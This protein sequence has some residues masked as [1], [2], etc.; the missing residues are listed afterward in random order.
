MYRVNQNL[1]SDLTCENIECLS[2][3]KTLAQMG[4]YF[5][6]P[7]EYPLYTQKV[8]SILPTFVAAYLGPHCL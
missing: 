3:T 1:L 5:R 2:K 4:M 7:L 6:F 8:R